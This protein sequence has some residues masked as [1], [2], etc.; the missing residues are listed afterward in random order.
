MVLFL[1]GGPVRT[2]Q[3]PGENGGCLWPVAGRPDHTR[4][5]ALLLLS[6]ITCSL[7]RNNFS[8]CQYKFGLLVYIQLF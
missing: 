7:R 5:P 4:D 3:R 6:G 8:A 2:S 1:A